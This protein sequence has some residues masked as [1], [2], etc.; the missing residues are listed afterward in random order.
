L[1]AE[2]RVFVKED[3]VSILGFFRMLTQQ[4]YT[5]FLKNN[6]FLLKKIAT[7]LPIKKGLPDR[8]AIPTVLLLE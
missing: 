3:F 5:L 7:C 6:F 2:L 1:G 8:H 4:I